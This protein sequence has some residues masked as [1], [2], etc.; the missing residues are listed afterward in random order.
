M[1]GK[2]RSLVVYCRSLSQIAYIESITDATNEVD[3]VK[4]MKSVKNA[5]YHFNNFV[6]AFAFFCSQKQ[7]KALPEDLLLKVVLI[8]RKRLPNN[9]NKTTSTFTFPFQN[10]YSYYAI[11]YQVI[12]SCICKEYY[13]LKSSANHI[14]N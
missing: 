4:T 3:R 1:A 11:R 9:L 10:F 8:S 14:T 12:Q 6:A 5:K 7:Q 13:N 2:V